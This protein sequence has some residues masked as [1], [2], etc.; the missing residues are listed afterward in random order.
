MLSQRLSLS[1][2]ALVEHG[3]KTSESWL[4]LSGSLASFP[5]APK[6]VK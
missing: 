5:S 3:K 4:D 6:A 2:L 1:V